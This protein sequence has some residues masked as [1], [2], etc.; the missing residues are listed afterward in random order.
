[1]RTTSCG[2]TARWW[3]IRGMLTR[4]DAFA[5]QLL[6][7]AQAENF[8]FANEDP[9]SPLKAVD[10]GTAVYCEPGTYLSARAGNGFSLM[11]RSP[12]LE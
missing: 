9:D 11:R 10:F 12:L 4:A 8:I 1:M 3:F 5:S 6:T 7:Y 2:G